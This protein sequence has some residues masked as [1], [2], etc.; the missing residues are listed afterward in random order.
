MDK[1]VRYEFELAV[2]KLN[3]EVETLTDLTTGHSKRFD[4]SDLGPAKCAFTW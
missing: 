1:V 3:L 4:L 2:I